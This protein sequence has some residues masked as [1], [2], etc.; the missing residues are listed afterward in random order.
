M[1]KEIT[2]MSHRCREL[3]PI[4]DI[5]DNS[6]HSVGLISMGVTIKIPIHE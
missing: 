1:E 4:M 3:I 2:E 6:E 5:V